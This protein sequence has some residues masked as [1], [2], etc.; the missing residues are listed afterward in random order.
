MKY[1][2]TVGDEDCER[3]FKQITLLL[4]LNQHLCAFRMNGVCIRASALHTSARIM[5]HAQF[6]SISLAL[7]LCV[8]TDHLTHSATR[9][10]FRSLDSRAY[11]M[12]ARAF[13][14]THIVNVTISKMNV[15]IA[16]VQL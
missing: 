7:I 13:R 9:T 2:E 12:H 6:I 11:L 8:S 10:L 14:Y 3:Y 15:A 16:Y 5:P 4:I 1:S